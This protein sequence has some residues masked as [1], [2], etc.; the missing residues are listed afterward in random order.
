MWCPAACGEF[1]DALNAVAACISAICAAGA[2][3]LA[4]VGIREHREA[5]A[6]SRRQAQYDRVVADPIIRVTPTFV[7]SSLELLRDAEATSSTLSKKEELHQ[8][9]KGT[10]DA[11]LALYHQ[12]AGDLTVRA[13]AWGDDSLLT[14]LSNLKEGLEDAVTQEIEKLCT[15]SAPNFPPLFRTFAAKVVMLVLRYD[16]PPC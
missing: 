15:P 1:W 4:V 7:D 13:S 8:H 11:W 3:Y 9:T 6:K 10:T 5:A 16:P 14:E 12:Y 2:T